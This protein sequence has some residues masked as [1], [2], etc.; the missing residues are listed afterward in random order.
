VLVVIIIG[1]LTAYSYSSTQEKMA[2]NLELGLESTAGVMATQ[3][4]AS[5]IEGL[6]PGDELN[7]QYMAV[8]GKLRTMRSMNDYIVNAYVMHVNPDQ[9][10]TF[11]VDDLY[12]DDPQ[13]S[14]K[15]GEVYTTPDKA[16]IFAAL[17]GPSA[18]KR[19]YTDKYGSFVSAYA[20]IDDSA[21]GS[22][23]NTTA[24]LGI[25]V[26]AKDF[27][28]YTH[29]EGYPIIATGIVSM[30][31]AAGAILYLGMRLRKAEQECRPGPK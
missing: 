30:I 11:I 4:N 1:A 5:E 21:S 27:A 22:N 9:T 10:I 17:S 31:L 23:G 18:S 2:Q 6:I 20:P 13:G 25:D 28:T 14:A 7:P 29:G 26:S 24:V 16:E 19:P 8:A 12:P 15:I 3:I